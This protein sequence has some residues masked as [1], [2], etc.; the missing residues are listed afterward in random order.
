MFILDR[1]PDGTYGVTYDEHRLTVDDNGVLYY[2][3][4]YP[5]YPVKVGEFTEGERYGEAKG[6]PLTIDDLVQAAKDKAEE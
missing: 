1:N 3:Q 6:P 5:P 2:S 4:M